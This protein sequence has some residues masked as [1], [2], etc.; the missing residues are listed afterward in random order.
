MSIF[1]ISILD[2]ESRDRLILIQGHIVSKG[3]NQVRLQKIEFVYELLRKGIAADTLYFA[4][5]LQITFADWE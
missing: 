3:I 4:F 2:Q 1:G 5:I